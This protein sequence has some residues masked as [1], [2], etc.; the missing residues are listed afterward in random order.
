M[1]APL[2]RLRTHAPA[3]LR[4]GTLGAVLVS[5]LSNAAIATDQA[6]SPQRPNVLFA[7]ADDWGRY[8]SAYAKLQPGGP[9][10]LVATPH[11]D[12][13]AREGV[14]ATHAFVNAPSCTP[15]RSALLSGQ[16]F[17]RCDRGAILQGAVWDPAIPSWPLLLRDAGYAIGFTYKVWSP[18]VPRDAPFGGREFAF[19][20]AGGRFNGFSQFVTRQARQS[21]AEVRPQAIADAKQTLYDE[22]AGN[23]RAFLASRRPDQ[24]FC[25]WFGPTN[26]HR[27]WVRGSGKDLWGI[28]PDDLR[29]KLPPFLP[30]VPTVREDFADYLGEV[31]AFDAGLGVLLRQLESIGELDNTL[32]VVSGDHGIP[33]FPNGKCNLYDFGVHVPL[34]IRWGERVPGGRVVSD[35][36]N[37]MDLAPTLLEAAGRPVP[38]VMTGTSLLPVLT[39]EQQGRVDPR[40]DYV[41]TGRERHVANIRSGQVPYPQ[42]AIRTDDF[43]YIRNFKPDRWP[44][45]H[46]MGHGLPEAQWPSFDKLANNT[47]AAFGDMDASPTKAWIIKHRD[48][49]QWRPY[50]QIAFG[51]RPAEELYD[52]AKDPHQ[53]NNVAEDPNYQ[54]QRRQLRERLLNILRQNGDPRV[55]EDPPRFEKPPYAGPLTN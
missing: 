45:G 24:P 19:R 53:V 1:I 4:L 38:D 46:A 26:C 3:A 31:Q 20:K 9:S 17:F 37:L 21:D 15:C 10:D 32:I 25:Y 33:G 23:F 41:V 29:G 47:F 52:L 16:Y 7:F 6:T 5:V 11:F 34:A 8:A 12:R 30:D 49:P 39:S 2:A 54:T 42:R 22:V 14:L 28:D 36:I 18:G 13:I 35:L 48:D 51:K 27:K 55:T 43:L 50:F 44:M 40:R